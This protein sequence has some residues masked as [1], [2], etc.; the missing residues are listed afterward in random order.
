MVGFLG[1]CA[2]TTDEVDLQY[3]SK[4]STNIVPGANAVTVQVNVTEGQSSNTNK[5][6]VK[7]NGYG[8]EMAPIVSRTSLSNLVK[9]AIQE[10]LAKEGFRIGPGQI[11]LETEIQKFYNDFKVGFL[12]WRCCIRGYACCSDQ[13]I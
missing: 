2:L 1:A 4:T 6:S 11:Y 3:E 5:V 12:F 10:E 7:K 13:D 9:S 8:I